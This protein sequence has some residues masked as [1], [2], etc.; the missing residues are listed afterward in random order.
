[1]NEFTFTVFVGI[2]PRLEK[3]DKAGWLRIK[4]SYCEGQN[5]PKESMDVAASNHDHPKREQ[6]ASQCV[7]RWCRNLIARAWKSLVCHFKT[8][9]GSRCCI[10]NA[11]S[12]RLRYQI[13][14]RL[15]ETWK[16]TTSSYIAVTQLNS[17]LL[18]RRFPLAD[19]SLHL[20]KFFPR[21]IFSFAL[22]NWLYIR[23]RNIILCDIIYTFF[24]SN[25]SSHIL[26]VI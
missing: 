13:W 22:T 24:A 3:K 7:G 10:Y 5:I 12:Q 17:C 26:Y 25:R 15:L 2:L 20:I 8:V 11:Y 19:K 21:F 1:M 23:R 6:L 14:K 4:P 16:Y 18:I 9:S